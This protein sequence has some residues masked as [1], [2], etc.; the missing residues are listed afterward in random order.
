M[1]ISQRLYDN[2]ATAAAEAARHYAIRIDSW[3][4]KREPYYFVDSREHV[5]LIDIKALLSRAKAAEVWDPA[6]R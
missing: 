4:S 3:K 1:N 2:S 5:A 6:C